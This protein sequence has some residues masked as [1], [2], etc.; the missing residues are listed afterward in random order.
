MNERKK[1]K[2]FKNRQ[3]KEICISMEIHSHWK[4]L[5]FRQCNYP[6]KYKVIE[7]VQYWH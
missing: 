4:F 2:S 3:L 7:G 5:W 1:M 6:Y